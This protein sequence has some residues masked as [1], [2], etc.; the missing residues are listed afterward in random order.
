[1][2]RV[3]RNKWHWMAAGGVVGCAKMLLAAILSGRGSSPRVKQ[4]GA[5]LG[6]AGTESV[7]P[8]K[9]EPFSGLPEPKAAV[10]RET[11]AGANG[12]AGGLTLRPRRIETTRTSA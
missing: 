1:M 10:E 7:Q 2:G 9:L 5:S 4:T 3:R 6:I 11:T 12:G 8:L